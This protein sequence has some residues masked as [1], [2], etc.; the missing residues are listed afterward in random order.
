MADKQCK[1]AVAEM[2]VCPSDEQILQIG[3]DFHRH[4]FSVESVMRPL[5]LLVQLKK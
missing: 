3:H 4:Y 2:V 1:E 5:K